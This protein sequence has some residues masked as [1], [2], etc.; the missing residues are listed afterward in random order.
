M[1]LLY[2]HPLS[3]GSRKVRLALGEKGVPVSLREER[4][5]DPR[6]EFL[7]L[8]PACEVPVLIEE[9]G[10]VLCGATAI[11][12]YLD[13]INLGTPLMPKGARE[14]AEVRRVVDWFDRKFSIEVS[15]AILYERVEKRFISAEQGGGAPDMD[16]VRTAM[17]NLRYHLDYIAYLMEQRRWLAGD[18]LSIADLTAAAHLSCMDYIGGVP[19]DAFPIAKDWYVR[20]KSRPGFRPLLADALPG[21]APPRS[22]ANLDF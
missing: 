19:W 5:W 1:R 4:V 3:P 17:H 12:E 7:E 10:T 11:V 2:H 16:I 14:R 13:D 8:N 18:T 20:L 15:D 21:M 6:P 9:D 22:Y